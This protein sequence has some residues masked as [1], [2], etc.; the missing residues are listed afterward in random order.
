[1]VSWG[2]GCA[3]PGYPGVYVKLSNPEIS[4]YIKETLENCKSTGNIYS[5]IKKNTLIVLFTVMYVL[6][7]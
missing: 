6:Y 5:N 3:R 1:M 7:T 4:S 2:R